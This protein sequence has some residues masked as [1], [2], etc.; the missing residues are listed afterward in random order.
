M[1]YTIEEVEDFA[2]AETGSAGQECRV[3]LVA[4]E[5]RDTEA[6]AL[7][8][9][10]NYQQYGTPWGWAPRPIR[11]VVDTIHF[12]RSTTNRGIQLADC[13]AFI[14]LRRDRIQRGLTDGGGKSAGAVIDLYERLIRPNVYV[15]N[16]WCP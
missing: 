2:Q 15:H 16:I 11:R 10:A 12:V 7:K 1:M 5:S 6:Q 3:L 14:T 9:L 13:V 4:D 8:G